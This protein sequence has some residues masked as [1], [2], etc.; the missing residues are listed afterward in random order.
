MRDVC[1]VSV[2]AL[3]GACRG[4]GQHEHLPLG[5]SQK[6]R[7]AEN[8]SWFECFGKL[9]AK[10]AAFIPDGDS[11]VV[12][13]TIK[14]WKAVKNSCWVLKFPRSYSPVKE[15]GSTG[16]PRGCCGKHRGEGSGRDVAEPTVLCKQPFSTHFSERCQ[17]RR[18]FFGWLFY[19]FFQG[20]YLTRTAMH[21]SKV[22]S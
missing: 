2:G 20:S 10:L 18:H 11:G 15:A 13:E 1:W 19:P 5:P 9:F 12:G 8:V 3:R 4:R 17:L 21:W 7:A 14:S 16:G 22:N 6:P